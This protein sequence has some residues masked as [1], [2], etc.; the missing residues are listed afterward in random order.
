MMRDR[1]F[2][3]LRDQLWETI[4]SRMINSADDIRYCREE[5]HP[6][7]TRNKI[8]EASTEVVTNLIERPLEVSTAQLAR[9][10]DLRRSNE[11]TLPQPNVW[12]FYYI[13][14]FPIRASQLESM[15][16]GWELSNRH[17]A[18]S[19]AWLDCI[20]S[21]RTAGDDRMLYMRYVGMGEPGE[22]AWDRFTEDVKRLK[23]GVLGAF[24]EELVNRYPKVYDA[25]ECHE[26]LPASYVRSRIPAPKKVTMDDRERI[27]IATFN[28]RYLLNVQSGGKYSAYTPLAS[29]H[30]LF[31]SLNTSFF[32]KFSQVAASDFVDQY[33]VQSLVD[34]WAERVREYATTHP[35]ETLTNRFEFT[36]TYFETVLKGQARPAVVHGKAFLVLFGKDVTIE[37]YTNENSFLSGDSQAGTFTADIL[38]KLH[39]YEHGYSQRLAMPFMDGQFPFVNMYPFIGK[40]DPASAIELAREYLARTQPRL[41][42]TFSRLVSSWTASNFVHAYGIPT[43]ISI[44]V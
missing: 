43:Y 26:I 37:D 41:I 35:A 29:D 11:E 14:T 30:T 1:Q 38:A 33:G 4:H 40:S 20:D 25:S 36:D 31:I 2:F 7:F 18:K 42:V 3:Q 5:F 23:S 21:A 22:T 39:Q 10:F 8:L 9:L 32:D 15:I 44:L 24:L 34:Q 13:R 19:Q 16:M 6:I 27:L 28:L 17:Y 12:M